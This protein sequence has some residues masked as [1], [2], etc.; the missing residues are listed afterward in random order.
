VFLLAGATAGRRTQW[1]LVF[2]SGLAAGV[3]LTAP[4]D[5]VSGGTAIQ[6]GKDV[7]GAF[8][9]VLAAV[10]S[11]VGAAVILGGALWSA[12]QFLRRR[13]EPG[14]ARRA[15]ANGLIALGTL[16]L[17][18]GGLTQGVVGHDEAFTLS[19][20]AGISVIYAGFL[21]AVS[22][23]S[24]R[25]ARRTILPRRFRGSSATSSKVAGTL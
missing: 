3:V 20:A 17:S 16:V 21:V 18:S 9:R 5:L 14:M 22:S 12:A 25:S 19:L 24:S 6:V 11:G 7:F 2:V 8:P 13:D 4:M 23:P 1:V 10:G 15:A